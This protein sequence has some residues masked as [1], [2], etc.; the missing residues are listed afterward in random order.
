MLMGSSSL[1]RNIYGRQLAGQLFY[2]K[3]VLVSDFKEII[4][5][6]FVSFFNVSGCLIYYRVFVLI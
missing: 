2:F 6:S 1:C 3:R 4:S 5:V